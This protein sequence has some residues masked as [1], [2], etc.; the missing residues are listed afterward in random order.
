M[1]E[2][3]KKELLNVLRI[4]LI[5]CQVEGRDPCKGCEEKK[6]CYLPQAYERIK[7]MIRDYAEHQELTAN[8]IDIVIDL[9]DQLEKKMPRV[10]EEWIEEKAVEIYN[11][12]YYKTFNLDQ[13]RGFIRL[14]VMENRG[15]KNE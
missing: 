7:E 14:L 4:K 9:Y 13:V 10:T 6:Y 15:K 8:Y 3:S 12:L 2:L 1:S 11:Y 5:G